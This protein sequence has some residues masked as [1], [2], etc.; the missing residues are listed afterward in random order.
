[1]TI[2][3]VSELFGYEQFGRFMTERYFS[4]EGGVLL[5]DERNIGL[6]LR[7][8][9]NM[10]KRLINSRVQALGPEIPSGMQGWLIGFLCE[11]AG[12]DTFQRDLEASF[13]IR[14]STATETLQLMEKN[15]LIRREPVAYDARLKR[16]VLTPKAIEYHERIG[17]CIR[18][19]EAQMA[20]GLTQAE[21]DAFFSI[22]SKIQK[23][24]E[25]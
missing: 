10:I 6:Q 3:F 11:R 4:S 12:Q 14:R 5:P 13:N 9:H 15:G 23:N 24:I 19:A 7:M 25:A 16:I 17:N 20:N 21:L 22:M 1:M 2:M 8:T 18:E